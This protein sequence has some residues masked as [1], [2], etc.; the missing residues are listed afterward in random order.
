MS[1]AERQ[2]MLKRNFENTGIALLETGMGWW[3]PNRRVKR[4]TKIIGLEHIEAAQKQGKGILLLAIHYLSAK[5]NCRGI[6]YGHPMVVFY[7]PHS[8][9]LMEYFQFR[10][11]SN[12][13]M[14]SKRDVKGLLRA[15]KEG[16]ACV[17]NSFI[18]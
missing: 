8:N 4:H 17:Y 12:K 7:R 14:L 15:L 18:N 3:W 1:D 13:Y 11:R 9:D 5:I 16:E 6:G 2:I 10:G